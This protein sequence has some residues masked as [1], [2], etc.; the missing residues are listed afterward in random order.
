MTQV[1]PR[2]L[3]L[4]LDPYLFAIPAAL[5]LGT[6]GCVFPLALTLLGLRARTA[7]GTASLSSFVQA[8]GYLLAGLGPFGF[9]WLHSATG[10]WQVPLIVLLVLVAP[11]ALLMSY[12]GRP[13][14][15]EDQISAPPPESAR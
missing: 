2:A 8:G 3:L 1:P 14:M 9:G 15:I 11:L 7:E 4:L 12:I 10:G 5:L 13:A 6:G